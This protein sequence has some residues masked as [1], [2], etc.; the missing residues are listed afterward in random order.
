MKY[1]PLSGSRPVCFYLIYSVFIY[2]NFTLHLLLR[3]KDC[4]TFYFIGCVFFC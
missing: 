2:F 1:R 3:F 4:L